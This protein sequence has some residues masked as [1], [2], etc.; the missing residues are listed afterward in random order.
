MNCAHSVTFLCELTRSA[1]VVL[2]ALKKPVPLETL[3][4]LLC[5]E[6]M[7]VVRIAAF[8]LY[9]MYPEIIQSIFTEATNILQGKSSGTF[10]ASITQSFITHVIE[11]IGYPVPE[12][13][14]KLTELLNWPHWLVRL[15]AIHAL[16]KLRRNVP[17]EAIRRLLDLRRDPDPMM[18]AIRQA[19]DEALA[20]ILLLET[21]IEDD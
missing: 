3:L 8:M 18:S 6:D 2:R 9:Q 13:L 15:N 5:D 20:E 10:L 17:D 12:F 7:E 4:L 11:G 19:A 21:G 16:K 14:D 1:L